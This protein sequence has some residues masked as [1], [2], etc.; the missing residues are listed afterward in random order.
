[1]NAIYECERCDRPVDTYESLRV[2]QAL[3]DAGRGAKPGFEP[4]ECLDCVTDEPPI[5][6]AR[7]E[8]P[9]WRTDGIATCASR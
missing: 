4:W 2:R 5:R 6:L 9:S 8:P 1:M 7:E 3:I